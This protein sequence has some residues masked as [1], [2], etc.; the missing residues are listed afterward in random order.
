M[1]SPAAGAARPGLR[2]S[3]A[4]SV[5]SGLDTDEWLD[6]FSPAGIAA[7]LREAVWWTFFA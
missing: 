7:G 2:P 5:S 6:L 3:S 4:E 1:E